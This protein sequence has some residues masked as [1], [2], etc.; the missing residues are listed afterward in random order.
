M[1]TIGVFKKI[2]PKS[3]VRGSLPLIN[4]ELERRGV[5]HDKL[6]MMEDKG[7]IFVIFTILAMVYMIL[8]YDVC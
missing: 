1:T 3:E 6:L 7:R 8:Y 5:Y 2:Q 4:P